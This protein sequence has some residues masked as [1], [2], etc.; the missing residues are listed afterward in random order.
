MTKTLILL[1]HPNYERSRANRALCEAASTLNDTEV[2]DMHQLYSDGHIDIDVEVSRLLAAARIVLQF[3][4]QWYST[5]SLLKAWQ[6][7]VLTHMF[8]AHP[9]TE[10]A[11]L[12]GKPLLVAATAGNV[13]EAYAAGGINLF[14]LVDLLR[15]LQA[16]AHRCGLPWFPLF[17]LYRANT[18]NAEELRAAG[19]RY[20]AHIEEWKSFTLEASQAPQST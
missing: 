10:G 7:S 15:P 2:V 5:P 19:Q 17:L 8:Y 16:T 18:L 13:P 20:R 11:R 1:F 12:E 3:P 14:P 9:D 6:D 4:V